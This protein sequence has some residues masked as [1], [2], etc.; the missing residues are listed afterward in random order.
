MKKYDLGF[1]S[2]EQIYAHVKNT[3]DQY[4]CVI[5]LALFNK[6]IVDPIKLTF[7]AKVYGQT[8]ERT[9]ES[10]CI[11]QIDKSNNNVI[12]YFHQHLFRLVG[13]GWEVPTAGFDVLNRDRHIYVEM[14]NKHNT[15]NA[16]SAK[17][18]YIKMQNQLLTDD[19]A[20]CMLVEVIA[21]R[22]QDTKWKINIDGRAYA[23]DRIRRVSIDQFYNIVFD[24]PS[25]F[26]K[27]C[28]RLPLIIDDVLAAEGQQRL[29]NTVNEELAQISPDLSKSLYLLAFQSYEG[30]DQF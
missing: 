27:R 19:Q 29:R 7:D 26:A 4:R 3:I 1:V 9:I 17:S 22:S 15:M 16:A 23:H 30:F 14:K 10:E 6:N 8:L 2:D 25:A 13:R 28:Q 24:D 20:T 11:R 18:T 5:D 21:K 12:G